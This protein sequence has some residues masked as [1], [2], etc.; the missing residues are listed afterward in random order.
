MFQKK[1]KKDCDK[2]ENTLIDYFWEE[3]FLNSMLSNVKLMQYDFEGS[4]GEIKR[5]QSFKTDF[6]KP[7]REKVHAAKVKKMTEKKDD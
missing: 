6:I 3:E 1:K 7:F 2:E 4:Q 5:K